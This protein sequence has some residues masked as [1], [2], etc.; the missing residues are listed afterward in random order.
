[1]KHVYNSCAGYVYV[2]YQIPLI[3]DSPVP[4]LNVLFKELCQKVADKWENIGLLLDIEEGR[5]SK[6]K[7]DNN[8]ISDNCLRE[9]L[10]IWTK[11][12]DPK[13]SWSSMADALIV[14]GEESLA[15]DIRT[16]Y[17]STN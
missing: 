15:G 4:K 6:V 17:C 16:T 1:M 2:H 3:T 7:S 8:N 14:L 13:P 10:K 9:M 12:V 5:L 11:K